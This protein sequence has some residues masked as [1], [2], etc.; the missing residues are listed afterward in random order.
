MSA[1]DRPFA[2][3]AD[4]GM[5]VCRRCKAGKGDLVDVE[6]A[7]RW[8]AGHYASCRPAEPIEARVLNFP[9]RLTGSAQP[10][11][12]DQEEPMHENEHQEWDGAGM[13][14]EGWWMC[15]HHGEGGGPG[16]QCRGCREHWGLDPEPP[17]DPQ[18]CNDRACAPC[19]DPEFCDDPQCAIC[20]PEPTYEEWVAEKIGPREVGG[21]YRT[22]TGYEYTVLSI[23]PG[24]RDSW[25][26]W[27]I[28]TRGVEDGAVRAH[29]TGWDE[30]D[31]VV[32]GPRDVVDW[33]A[34][35]QA[36]IVEAVLE[37]LEPG[38]RH[39]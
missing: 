24:P 31:Q 1:L 35:A 22:Y 15:P 18:A 5:A 20:G 19:H 9:T 26:T 38:G 12:D 39:R 2:W 28:T 37:T 27:Q 23:E 14:P 33:P 7:A 3:Y 30:R 21:R 17:H 29:C 10:D 6:A 16:E 36:A 34:D 13:P 32:S 8:H 4:A 11:D 25:P